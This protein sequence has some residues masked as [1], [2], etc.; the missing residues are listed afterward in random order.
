MTALLHNKLYAIIFLALSFS[1]IISGCSKKE[2]PKKVSLNKRSPASENFVK[3]TDTG[4]LKFG[5]DLRLNPKEDVKIYLPF[6]R[7]LEQSTGNKFS[8]R[9]TER[10]EDTVENLGKGIIHFAALGP[11][12]SVLARKKYGANCLVMGLNSEGKPRYRAV[13]FT[14]TGSPIKDIT[15]LKGKFFA[16][17]DN[18]STQG[19]IIPRR[20][21]EDAGITL[22]SLKGYV[23]TGS[24]A[25]TARAVLN[26]EYDAGAIQDNLA[27]RLMSE[28]KIKILATSKPYPSSL[29][30][31]SKEVHSPIVKNVK[32]ALL[33]LDPKG[34]HSGILTNWD[35][36]EMPNGFTE[37]SDESLKEIEELTIRYGLLE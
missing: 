19:H 29:I 33:G 4:S 36:T 32:I 24:H 18:Y 6:L 2:I 25:N 14:K 10:Y 28:G 37:Y 35:K 34:K 13:I 8:L 3:Q 1:L 23:F 16:F 20:M 21:L 11:V 5:F 15:D 30:C 17:G 7:Y 27:I 31:Y 22:E 26:G 9:F 12:N